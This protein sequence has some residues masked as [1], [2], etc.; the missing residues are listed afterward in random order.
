[1]LCL[2]HSFTQQTWLDHYLPPRQAPLRL[3]KINTWSLPGGTDN[4]A[5]Q[6]DDGQESE[7]KS[8]AISESTRHWE[9]SI[10][11][12]GNRAVTR[13]CIRWASLQRGQE[14]TDVKEEK[15]HSHTKTQ[16]EPQCTVPGAGASCL[17][18]CSKRGAE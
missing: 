13:S 15:G 2:S 18:D 6:T 16:G 3:K 7:A 11:R 14:N 1:M 8:G 17:R 4:P 10:T 5:G 9:R 12:Q